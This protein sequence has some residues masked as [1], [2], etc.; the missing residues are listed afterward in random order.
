MLVVVS[1]L[2]AATVASVGAIGF[3]GLIVPHAVRMVIG[4][5]HKRLIPISAIAGAL[6]LVIAD[7]IARVLFAPQELPVGV[8]TALIGVP[9]FFVILKRIAR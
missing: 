5:L 7:A 8:I 4:P 3:V 2:T 1:L 9:V 6:F